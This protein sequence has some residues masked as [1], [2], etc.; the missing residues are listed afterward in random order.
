MIK[1]V[2]VA[3]TRTEGDANALAA[4]IDLATAEGAH[5][6]VLVTVALPV[7][8]P[9][10]WGTYPADLYGAAYDA[11][12]SEGE[13]AAVRLRAQTVNAAVPVEVRVAE[14]QFQ[15]ARHTVA[16]HARHADLT[17]ITGATPG[18][19]H[20]TANA[21]FLEALMDSG[22][23]VLVVPPGYRIVLPAR[24]AVIAWQPTREAARAVHDALPL[25][26]KAELVDVLTVD[27]QISEGGHGE[28]P[29][30]DIATH[31]AR[32]GLRVRV[33]N[34]RNPGDATAKVLLSHAI[35]V[36]ADLLVAGGFSHSR[37]RELIIGGVTRDLLATAHVPVLFSH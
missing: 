11:A 28:Q 12:R 5:L 16:V 8:I 35:E 27:A 22:R 36:G 17:V 13:D 29:G 2:L 33:V 18:Q 1:D 14:S 31:L 3:M 26:R 7:M 23:P 37:F 24:R 30:A 9:S 6:A 19:G 34:V 25:L 21:M 20:A 10:E 15:T 4:A 32:H